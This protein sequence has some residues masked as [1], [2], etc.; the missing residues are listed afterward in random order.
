MLN[1]KMGFGYSVCVLLARTTAE[2]TH[3]IPFKTFDEMF[4]W[5]RDEWSGKVHQVTVCK[6]AEVELVHGA[7]TAGRHRIIGE[8]LGALRIEEQRLREKF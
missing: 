4:V 6:D 8:H 2:V 5:L 1:V 3:H 7:I